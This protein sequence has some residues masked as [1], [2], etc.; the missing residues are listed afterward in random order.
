MLDL[1]RAIPNNDHDATL[2]EGLFQL[3]VTGETASNDF[4][5]I[6]NEVYTRLLATYEPAAN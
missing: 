3:T 4:E 5:K 6:D 2:L 1:E